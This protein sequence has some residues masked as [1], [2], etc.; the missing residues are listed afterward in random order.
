MSA[1]RGY[2]AMSAARAEIMAHVGRN[3]RP[4][5]LYLAA[6][7]VLVVVGVTACLGLVGSFGELSAATQAR[8]LLQN[9]LAGAGAKF[10]TQPPPGSPF[11]EGGS[12]TLAGAALQQRVALAVAEA[13]GV[14]LSSQIDLNGP[15][16]AEGV[17]QIV[18]SGDLGQNG[19]QKA[20]H[21]LEGG[22]PVLFIDRLVVQAPQSGDA[23]PGDRLHVELAVS[24]QWE[25]AR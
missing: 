9:R 2:A 10:G 11:L 5:A 12:P 14:V 13:G 25:G 4:V 20:I 16:A 15:R 24:G 3:W 6:L 19:L 18:V 8:D 21:D 22:S 1:E 7:I 23:A 17:I